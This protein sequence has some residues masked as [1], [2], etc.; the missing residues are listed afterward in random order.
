MTITM[1]HP[2]SAELRHVYDVL[3]E[4]APPWAGLAFVLLVVT[5]ARVS[6]I[7]SLRWGQIVDGLVVVP[8]KHGQR[9]VAVDPQG[10]WLLLA[11]RPKVATDADPVLAGA[12]ETVRKHM[13]HQLSRACARAGVPKLNPHDI[14]LFVFHRYREE[15]IEESVTAA[16]L[17]LICA[18]MARSYDPV[19]LDDQR[20]AAL[21][22]GLGRALTT[23]IEADV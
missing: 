15:S 9:E 3:L 11:A 6:E 16:Q 21:N 12:T 18:G 14:R 4:H 7:P 10:Y 20:A 22:V 13:G 1:S 17:G 5:G 2:S 23:E 19:E 8:G